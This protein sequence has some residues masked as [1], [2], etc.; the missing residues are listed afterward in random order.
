MGRGKTSFPVKR[1]FSSPRIPP[2]FTG[3][4]ALFLDSE[5]QPGDSVEWFARGDMDLREMAVVDRIRPALGFQA[6]AGIPAVM[7]AVLAAFLVILVSFPRRAEMI[8]RK[9]SQN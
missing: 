8:A 4:R 6:E 9:N 7:H 3:N 5:L 1:S 2:H